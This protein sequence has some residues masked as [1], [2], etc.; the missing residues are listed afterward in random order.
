MIVAKDLKKH[1]GRKAVLDGVSFSLTPSKIYGLIGCNGAGKTTLLKCIAGLTSHQGSIL[2]DRLPFSERPESVRMGVM[3]ETP[4]FFDSMTGRENLALIAKLFDDPSVVHID[5]AI[6]AVENLALIA[7][8]FDD[9]SVVH[10]DEAIAAVGMTS[11]M[12]DKYRTYSL[13]MKQRLYFAYAIMADPE[14]LLLDEPFNGVD[15]VTM[16]VFGNLLKQEKEK[17]KTV[18]IS[19]HMI[20]ELQELVDGALILDG[21]KI[22]FQT[23]DASSCDLTEKFLSIAATSEGGLR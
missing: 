13:G 20:R 14:I 6:A 2:W 9:P 4:V 5:E 22:A 15:P 18:L 10:I 16:N 19:S 17:G 8:L 1:Y 21:G 7:K 11:K 3:I 12:N 23:E